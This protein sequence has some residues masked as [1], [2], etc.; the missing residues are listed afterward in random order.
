MNPSRQTRLN[1]PTRRAALQI[2]ATGVAGPT[3]KGAGI[4]L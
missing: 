3:V 2:L 1:R 4:K